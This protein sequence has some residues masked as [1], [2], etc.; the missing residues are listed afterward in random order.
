MSSLTPINEMLPSINILE[1]RKLYSSNFSIIWINS[2][3]SGPSHDVLLE[4]SVCHTGDIETAVKAEGTTLKGCQVTLR[5]DR[6]GPKG[7]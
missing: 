6:E 7:M 4:S 2:S 3:W 5:N 1:R